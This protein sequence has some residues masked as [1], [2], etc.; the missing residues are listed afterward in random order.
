MDAFKLEC[1]NCKAEH[2]LP[3]NPSVERIVFE[4]VGFYKS[5]RTRIGAA[6]CKEEH[7]FIRTANS[8]Q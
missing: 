5:H 4:A 8:P 3:M 7:I 1:A 2:E 6:W